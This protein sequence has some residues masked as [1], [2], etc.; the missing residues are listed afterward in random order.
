MV[1]SNLS[2]EPNGTDGARYTPLNSA[3]TA[4]MLN[5]VAESDRS[6]LSSIVF[7]PNASCAGCASKTLSSGPRVQ[8]PAFLM[9]TVGLEA[10]CFQRRAAVI[11][12]SERMGGTKGGLRSVQP[13]TTAPSRGEVADRR[14]CVGRVSRTV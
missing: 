12:G 9:C 5:M 7:P 11:R 4:Q 1:M 10:C 13:V 14:L 2:R 6:F 3:Y 8:A